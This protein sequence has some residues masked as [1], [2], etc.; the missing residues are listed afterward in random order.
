[1]GERLV[2][3]LRQP[4]L[5][6]E[7]FDRLRLETV[8]QRGPV[9]FLPVGPLEDHDPPGAHAAGFGEGRHGIV[10]LVQHVPEE[11]QVERAVAVR[12][13]LRG[14]FPECDT[15][16]AAP[17]LVEQARVDINPDDREARGRERFREHAG[18]GADVEDARGCEALDGQGD[19]PADLQALDPLGRPQPLALALEAPL[20]RFVR[21]VPPRQWYCPA[22][23][24]S[25]VRRRHAARRRWWDDVA[26]QTGY[27]TLGASLMTT[28]LEHA[29]LPGQDLVAA[30]IAD[31][32]R[33][34][35]SVPALLASIGAP[36]LQTVGVTLPRVLPDAEHRLYELLARDDPDAAHSRYNALVRRLVSFERAL[37]CAR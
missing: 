14:R 10:R 1:M 8:V 19:D 15:G 2:L 35:E 24:V 11:G 22:R 18:A 20:V 21:H 29:G 37:A 36:R 12:N 17:G 33:G 4:R 13:G 3:D 23:A 7:G 9:L 31:L 26:R 30:G 32:E 25:P 34:V 27:L 6:G 16:D 28:P 5:P